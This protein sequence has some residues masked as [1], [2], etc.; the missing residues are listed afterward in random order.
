[1]RLTYDPDADAA[2]VYFVDVIAAGAV[3]RT[4]VSGIELVGSVIIVDFDAEGKILGIE[5]LGAGR[6]LARSTLD[7]V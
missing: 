4:E 7:G 6:V 3:K 5:I 1:M 2:Y